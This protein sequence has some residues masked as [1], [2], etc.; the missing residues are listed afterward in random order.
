MHPPPGEVTQLLNAWSR[1]DPEALERLVPVVEGELRR[2]ARSY[3]S[4]EQPGETLQPT[5]LVN[6]AYVRL[7]G[8]NPVEWQNRTHFYA[9]AAKMMRRI[10]VNQA[11]SRGRKKRGG[12][13]L[14]VSLAEAD[15]ASHRSADILA[16]DEALIK[17]ARIDDRRRQLVELRFFGG[18]TAEETAEVLSISVRTVHREWDL[19]RAWLFRELRG[20]KEAQQQ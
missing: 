3:L 18:L 17:L 5:A 20:R 4:R 15:Q 12:S 11:I 19:A 8:W 6:E 13:A 7:I 9:V 2:L 14:L 16:L 10:L 1:G